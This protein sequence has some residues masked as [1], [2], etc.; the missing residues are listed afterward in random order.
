MLVSTAVLRCRSIK[1]RIKDLFSVAE[2][3]IN[4]FSLRQPGRAPPR[5]PPA[6]MLDI[7]TRVNTASKIMDVPY[8]FVRGLL[9]TTIP[10]NVG[11]CTPGLNNNKN[12]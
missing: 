9:R 12:A 6:R 10:E 3:Q 8:G 4:A 5:V 1:S 2:S 7:V 11:S